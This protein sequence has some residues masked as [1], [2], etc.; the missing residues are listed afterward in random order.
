MTYKCFLKGDAVMVKGQNIERYS[1]SSQRYV[2]KHVKAG[3]FSLLISG[4][5][6]WVLRPLLA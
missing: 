3:S 1:F 4:V 6:F 5:G 2:K